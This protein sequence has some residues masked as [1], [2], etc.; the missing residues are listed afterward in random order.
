MLVVL[1]LIGHALAAP[2]VGVDYVPFG[3][4]DIAWV[5]E[6][7][8]SGSLVGEG[9][10]LVQPELTAWGGAAGKYDAVLFGLGIARISTSIYVEDEYTTSYAATVRP[11]VDYRRYLAPRNSGSAVGFMQV[12]TY[13]LIPAAGTYSDTYTRSEQ[14]DADQAAQELRARIG[15][16]GFRAG[17]GAEVGWGSGLTLG[18]RYLFV[19]HRTQALGEDNFTVSTLVHGEAALILGFSL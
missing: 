14:N 11:S 6:G 15:G 5:E 19:F 13:G 17:G 9:D 1:Q 2:Y 4:Q 18:A 7:Q 16:F 8:L 12:G 3:R 10:G